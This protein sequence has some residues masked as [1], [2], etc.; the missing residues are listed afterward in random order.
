[1]SAGAT[2]TRPVSTETAP[3]PTSEI[4]FEAS[5]GTASAS[6]TQPTTTHLLR[7]RSSTAADLRPERLERRD[8]RRLARRD[9]G[10]GDGDTDAEQ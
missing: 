4:C 5:I 2:S 9:D 7:C 8:A 10:A 6:I 3:R 1:M